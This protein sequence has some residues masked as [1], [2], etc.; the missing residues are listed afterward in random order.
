MRD[1]LVE[2]WLDI[3]PADIAGAID[4]QL[5]LPAALNV[6]VLALEHELSESG[7]VIH[8]VEDGI[9]QTFSSNALPD[10]FTSR[11]GGA[12]VALLDHVAP[13]L[14]ES[15]RHNQTVL[16]FD[17][18]DAPTWAGLTELDGQ[19]R[20]PS[21][22]TTAVRNEVGEAIGFIE[23]ARTTNNRPHDDELDLYGRVARLSGY[24]I[25]ALAAHDEITEGT[26]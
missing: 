14:A 20:W 8:L 21:V 15:L 26:G 2:E 11:L 17:I 18:G 1:L 19:D 4:D 22:A 13:N 25:E 16:E 3:V 7:A 12:P 5:T 24:L 10:G 23:V 6:L 9:L